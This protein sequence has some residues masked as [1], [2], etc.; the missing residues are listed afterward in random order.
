MRARFFDPDTSKQA[1]DKAAVFA[2]SHI[3]RIQAAL[4]DD[5]MT[6]KEISRATGLTV[7][8]ID[9]RLPELERQ[10][11]AE[12]VRVDGVELSRGGYRVWRLTA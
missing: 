2:G 3:Q 8:Q 6:A 4:A 7:V 11:L 1:A 10:G 12:V 5:S 9:R